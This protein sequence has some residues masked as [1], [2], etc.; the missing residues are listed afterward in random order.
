MM[1]AVLPLGSF[2]LDRRLT[3]FSRFQIDFQ[4]ITDG[5]F[6]QE[7]ISGFNWWINFVIIDYIGLYLQK[8]KVI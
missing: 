3:G 4:L 1:A 5:E 7:N 8:L 6:F 2:V